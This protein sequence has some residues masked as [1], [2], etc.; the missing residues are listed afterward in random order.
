M[1]NNCQLRSVELVPIDVK[2]LPQLL[3]DCKSNAKP[4]PDPISIVPL[5]LN[6]EWSN[7]SV[8]F[9]KLCKSGQQWLLQQQFTLKNKGH[10]TGKKI[11]GDDGRNR[12]GVHVPN[13]CVVETVTTTN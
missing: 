6:P 7:Q 8:G 10:S 9:D 1:V 5:S 13:P 11:S 3:K 4:T 12:R 2:R